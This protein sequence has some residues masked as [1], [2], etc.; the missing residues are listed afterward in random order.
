ML[1]SINVSIWGYCIGQLFWNC[2][3]GISCFRFKESLQEPYNRVAPLLWGHE[4]GKGLIVDGLDLPL[5]HG[6]PS[7]IAD[8]LPDT[9]KLYYH[10]LDNVSPNY[11]AFFELSQIGGNGL[12]ALEYKSEIPTIKK[13]PLRLSHF[14]QDGEHYS[15]S[16]NSD[17]DETIKQMRNPIGGRK[18]KIFLS[19]NTA[20]QEI[21]IGAPELLEAYEHFILK[22]NEAGQYDSIIEYIYYLAAVRSGIKMSRSFL[23]TINGKHHFMTK[24]FDIHN[25]GKT[26]TQTLA[27]ISPNTNNYEGL[28]L[29]A[30][31]IGVPRTDYTELFRRMIFNILANNTDDH[32]KN[33]SFLMDKK[34]KWFLSPA[35]DLLF[36]F[37]YSTYNPQT[38]HSLS[39]NDK[40]S[41]I[42]LPDV[43][44]IANEYG[45]EQPVEIIND[46]I[47]SLKQLPK[48]F[49]QYGLDKAPEKIIMGQINRNI[50]FL[51]Q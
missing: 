22:Y 12:G 15:L 33:F 49:Q 6:L 46:V 21:M 24:R 10:C 44:D 40:R 3:K 36:S 27:A 37:E 45:I 29:V 28:F 4:Q 16:S 5:Y 14:I 20:K 41:R 47:E 7:F 25:G 8:S 17:I 11:R 35:Y 34:G 23:V 32:T 1:N 19:F 43:I 38:S 48:D 26:H 31:R 39:V 9:S 30:K 18:R 42:I 2:S 51:T 50:D 13:K